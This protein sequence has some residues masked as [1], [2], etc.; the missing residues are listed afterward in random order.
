M[1]MTHGCDSWEGSDSGWAGFMGRVHVKV[2][3]S[4]C[5][6]HGKIKNGILG[7]HQDA[8]SCWV[9]CN[10]LSVVNAMI[11]SWC[12]GM[13]PSSDVDYDLFKMDAWMRWYPRPL[14]MLAVTCTRAIKTISRDIITGTRDNYEMPHVMSL[15]CLRTTEQAKHVRLRTNKL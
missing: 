9:Y 7:K 14:P 2:E 1:G 4:V 11:C 12:H 5:M 15:L 10:E 8:S 13:L 3:E 6:I